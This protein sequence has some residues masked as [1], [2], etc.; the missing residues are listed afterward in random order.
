M[1]DPQKPRDD[2]GRHDA[3]T[4]SERPSVKSLRWAA[5]NPNLPTPRVSN[6]ARTRRIVI[7]GAL[8]AFALTA[9][10]IAAAVIQLFAI[11]PQTAVAVVGATKISKTQL[12]N[13]IKLDFSNVASRYSN[14][15]QT[16]AQAQAQSDPASPDN[17][18]LL[19]FYQQQLQQAGSQIDASQISRGS[20]NSLIDEQ[21]IRQEAGARGLTVT[22]DEI[23]KAIQKE[24]GYFPEPLPTST[25]PA[26]PTAAPG[27]TAEPPATPEPLPTSVSEAELQ[28]GIKRGEDYYKSFGFPTTDFRGLFELRLL[29]QKLHEDFGKAIPK[30]DSQLQFDYIRFNSEQLANEGLSKAN[31]DPAGFATLIS[32]TNA[33]TLPQPVG[34]GEH[35]DWTLSKSVAARYGDYV[36]SALS[37]GQIGKVTSAYSPTISSYYVLVPRGNE[38]RPLTDADISSQQ[39]S[40]YDSWLAKAKDA[41]GKVTDKVADPTTLVPKTIKD[42]ITTFQQNQSRSAP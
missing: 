10:L 36:L 37:A 8:A 4:A 19:Q 40:L 1:A 15:Q 16:V 7:Y 22:G 27:A 21:L 32:T 38:V 42:Q 9:L 20:L 12:Q 28:T 34:S 18:F 39:K 11:E 14:L 23:D 33:I 31:S 24:F 30:Q 13:R 6:E 5:A 29:D 3:E 41:G 26:P 25:P 2:S 17:N 35:V